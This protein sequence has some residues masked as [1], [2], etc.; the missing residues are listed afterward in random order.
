[1]S[2]WLLSLLVIIHF[3][4]YHAFAGSLLRQ[5]ARDIGSSPPSIMLDGANVTGVNQGALSKFLGIPYAQPPVGN[6]RFRWPQAIT[7]Y[8][9]SINATSYGYSCPQQNVTAPISLKDIFNATIPQV[10]AGLVPSFNGSSNAQPESEDCLTINVI[11]P[12]NVSTDSKLPVVVWIFGGG[13]ERGNPAIY[14]DQATRVVNRSMELGQPIVY[15]AMNYRVSAFGF[16]ASKEVQAAGQGNAGL[17]DQYVALQWV[18][19][20]I[21]AFGGDS[22]RVTIW[23]QSAGAISASLQMLAFGGNTTNLF[24]GAFMQSGS[25]VP[26][27]NITGGQQYYDQLVNQTNCSSSNDTLTCLQNVQYDQLKAA[28]DQTPSYFSYQ[29]LV[30]AWSPRADGI[31]LPDNPQRLL[32]QGKVATIPVVSGNVDDEGTI[33]SLSSTNITTDDQFEQ[34]V[35]TYF[36][37]NASPTELAPLWTYYPSDPSAGSPFNTSKLNQLSP[38]YKRIAAFQGDAVLQAPRRFFLDHLLAKNSSTPAWSFLSLHSKY[39]PYVGSY[40]GSDLGGFLDDYLIQFIYNLDP[41]LNNASPAWPQYT[42]SSPVLYTFPDFDLGKPSPEISNDT[43]RQEPMA[44]LMNLSLSY[45]L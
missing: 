21:G 11:T 33:F 38:Q 16:L 6:L 35:S 37:P 28:V 22:S 20:Y 27:G 12:S 24:R 25:P 7:S 13:F 1:M 4:S 30:L 43:Y 45:P 9:G 41:N 8:N 17:V 40:H 3:T 36:V 26:V 14:D 23:G 32:Q 5:S 39:T 10:I 15:A 44:Y 19:K 34:Y 18:Q 29:S 31:F 42:N 2:V